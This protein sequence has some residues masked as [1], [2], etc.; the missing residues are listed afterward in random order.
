MLISHADEGK[1]PFLCT[2]H[3]IGYDFR[4]RFDSCTVLRWIPGGT[5]FLAE[6]AE[7]YAIV[8]DESLL[9]KRLGEREMPE[10]ISIYVFENDFERMNYALR[11]GWWTGQRAAR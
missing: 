8:A 2:S 1:V 5:V 11:L 7:G 9:A 3:R 10:P 4:S 6:G